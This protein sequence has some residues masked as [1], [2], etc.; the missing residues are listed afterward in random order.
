M[1]CFFLTTFGWFA[2]LLFLNGVYAAAPSGT[3]DIRDSM[4]H[5]GRDPH[6]WLTV[7]SVL[8]ILGLFELSM[9]TLK[10]Y[11]VVTGMWKWPPWRQRTFDGDVEEWDIQMWQEL[12]QDP[13]MWER[14]K[15]LARDESED[16][17]G[18]VEVVVDVLE[19]LHKRG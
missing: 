18:S 5:W 8:S 12:E 9:K 13:V 4:S 1:F 14:F 3:Y 2:W 11:M 17:D 16:D 10:R 7:F 6:W 15:R 19:G